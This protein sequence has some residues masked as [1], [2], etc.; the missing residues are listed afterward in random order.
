METVQQHRDEHGRQSRKKR[1][2]EDEDHESRWRSTRS[3]SD[4]KMEDGRHKSLAEMEG[5]RWK[6]LAEIKMEDGR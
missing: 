4:I 1:A 3:L 5:G 6:S 2:D